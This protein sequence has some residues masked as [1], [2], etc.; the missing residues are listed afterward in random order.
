MPCQL[1]STAESLSVLLSPYPFVNLL[2]KQSTLMEKPTMTV[3]ETDDEIA[4]EGVHAKTLI[5]VL[6]LVAPEFRTPQTC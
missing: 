4:N 6:V 1:V 3:S 5:L 2:L